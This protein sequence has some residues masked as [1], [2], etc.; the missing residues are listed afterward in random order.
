MQV[1]VWPG[2]AKGARLSPA[3]TSFWCLVARLWKRKKKKK[4]KKRPELA[5][6][7]SLVDASVINSQHGGIAPP[8]QR[9]PIRHHQDD[10]EKRECLFLDEAIV[11]VSFELNLGRA[12]PANGPSDARQPCAYWQCWAQPCLLRGWR[13]RDFVLCAP[14]TSFSPSGR[15]QLVVPASHGS[16]RTPGLCVRAIIS[17]QP[18]DRWWPD[19]LIGRREERLAC[20]LASTYLSSAPT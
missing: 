12:D 7:G 16:P 2:I 19:R 10:G 3:S 14:A 4:Q 18:V 20:W 17:P 15:S 5:S 1:A 8:W 13:A 11:R 9:L 6:Q